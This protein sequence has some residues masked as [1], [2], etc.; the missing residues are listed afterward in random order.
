MLRAGIG[1]GLDAAMRCPGWL[2]GWA[3]GG[4]RIGAACVSV[5]RAQIP[6]A[7]RPAELWTAAPAPVS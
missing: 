2:A 6:T 1:L 4:G 3:R 7:G 5:G